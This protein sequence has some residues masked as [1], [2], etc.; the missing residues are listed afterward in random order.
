MAY[1]VLAEQNTWWKPNVST[2]TRASITEI[3]IID[4]YTPDASVTVVDSWDASAANDGS[5]TCYVI[6]TK[7][8]MAGNDS[9]KLAMPANSRRFFSYSTDWKDWFVN[10]KN[11]HGANLLDFSNVTDTATMFYDCEALIFVDVSEWDL[12]NVTYPASMFYGCKAL[13]SL[14]VSKWNLSK[15]TNTSSMF[16]DCKVLTSIDCSKW[17]LSSVTNIGSMFCGCAMIKNIDVSGWNVSNVTSAY[18]VF[19]G[20]TSLTSVNLSAWHTDNTVSCR[21]MFLEC[22]SI[23]SVDLSNLNRIYNIESM[24]LGCEKLIDVTIGGIIIPEDINTSWYPLKCAFSDCISLKSIDV[25]NIIIEATVEMTSMFSGCSSL[26]TVNFLQ[27][28]DFSKVTDISFMLYGCSSLK[29]IDVSNWDVSNVTNF[30]HFAAHANLKR[31]GIENWKTTSA[32]NMNAIFH[33]CA[34]EELDL[35]GWDVSKVQFF[36]Q[37]FE[38]SPNLKRIKGLEKWDTSAGLGFDGMFERCAK[39]EEVD[40]SSFDTSKAKNGVAASTN[41]HTTATMNSMFLSCNNLKKVKVGP[42]FSINGDG[43]NTTAAN[44]AVLPTP[45]A[46]YIAGADGNWYGFNG[47]SYAPNAMKD[48][49][50]E[51]YY[52]SYDIVADLDVVV[53]NGSI[54]DIAKAIRDLNGSTDKLTISEMGEAIRS[55]V[56][57]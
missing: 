33:N 51:T 38:N 32:V 54:I 48:R 56:C 25:H 36:C 41:G 14:D 2:V 29:E 42:N 50:A 46:D 43:T 55:H 9:G 6:G 13:Q 39:L 45:S 17:D 24:F 27:N 4:S 10:L 40:L 26:Q 53:K 44:K 47:D 15:A 19:Q 52:A 5:I 49:T 28:V 1:P 21:Q 34:E 37:M 22:S 18:S 20:C 31:K 30:D 11:I 3:E 35:S 12:S 16:Q 57:G 7:L 23:T 8:I